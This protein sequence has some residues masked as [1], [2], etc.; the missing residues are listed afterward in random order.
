MLS[1]DASKEHV[2]GPGQSSSIDNR[3]SQNFGYLGVG[4]LLM[5]PGEQH[6]PDSSEKSDREQEE[7]ARRADNPTGRGNQIAEYW[8]FAASMRARYN[9]TCHVTPPHWPQSLQ[10]RLP[11]IFRLYQRW[12]VMDAPMPSNT[13]EERAKHLN[14]GCVRANGWSLLAPITN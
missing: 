1:T 5:W 6:E 4:K 14:T 12:F 2:G 10:C 13:D 9:S 3:L 8:L 11:A 7:N